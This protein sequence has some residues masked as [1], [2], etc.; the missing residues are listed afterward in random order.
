MTSF[1]TL[2]S[3]ESKTQFNVVFDIGMLYVVYTDIRIIIYIFD[4]MPYKMNQ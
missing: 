4:N 2:L 1:Y 3:I